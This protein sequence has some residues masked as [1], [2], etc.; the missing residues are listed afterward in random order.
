MNY[1]TNSLIATDVF[2]L[3]IFKKCLTQTCFSM[4]VA[5]KFH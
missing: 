4:W 3:Q 2:L 1:G 5:G